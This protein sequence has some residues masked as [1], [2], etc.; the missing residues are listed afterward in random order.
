[1]LVRSRIAKGVLPFPGK[2]VCDQWLAIAAAAQGRVVFVD[3]PLVRYRQHGANQTGVLSGVTD[4]NSYRAY[5]IAPLAERLEFYRQHWRPSAA[6][7]K[8]VEARQ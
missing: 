6:L 3:R 1:M 8:F 2:T 7:E 5:K 4:K